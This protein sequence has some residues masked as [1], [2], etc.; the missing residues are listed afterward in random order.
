MRPGTEP[1]RS[2]WSC[3]PDL[4]QV[5]GPSRPYPRVRMGSPRAGCGKGTSMSVSVGV[6]IHKTTLV[7]S[8]DGERATT[9]PNTTAGIARLLAHAGSPARVVL[10]PSGGYERPLLAALHAAGVPV[11]RVQP[12]R[13]RAFAVS[14][15]HAAKSDPLDARV[16]ARFGTVMA[17]RLTPAPAPDAAH[18][19]ALS[20]RRAQWQEQHN[21]ASCRTGYRSRRPRL[22]RRGAGGPGRPGD[23][24]Q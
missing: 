22:L 21:A 16:L 11:A 7:V 20:T 14:A 1:G 8:R 5:M 2:R 4:G 23:D 24:D 17:P 9:F 12:Y 15:G 18:W 13:V 3:S 6:D 10:E 19:H